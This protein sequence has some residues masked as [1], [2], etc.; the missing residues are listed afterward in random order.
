M[1]FVDEQPDVLF[2][3]SGG[4]EEAAAHVLEED[5][6]YTLIS[7]MEGN[8]NAAAT[9]VK[10]YYN[11]KGAR[12]ILLDYDDRGTP[13]FLKDLYEAL[14]GIKNLQG[15]TLGLLGE[16]SSWLI[17]SAIQP[18]LLKTKLGIELKRIAWDSLPNYKEQIVAEDLVQ[19][20]NSEIPLKDAGKVYTLLQ[21]W[22]E[23][24]KLD[25]ITVECFSL[26]T[27]NAVTA[28]LPLAKLNADG[29]PAGCEGDL[30]SIT[31]M[32]LAK[33]VTGIVP[34]IA[35]TVKVSPDAA[36]FAH[37]TA[38][39]TLLTEHTVTTH[40]ETGKGT[41]I[42]GRWATDNITIFRLNNTLNNAFIAPGKVLQRPRH[43]EA[44]RTQIEVK[45]PES[46]VYSL[47]ENPLGNHHLILPHDYTAT[48][49]LAC[50]VLGI[51]L[52]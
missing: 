27:E 3:L 47:R 22:I 33:E 7:F 49:S 5:K 26:I 30:V 32:M 35:N 15:Q 4:S 14:K 16:V 44:C 51:E 52:Q 41:A 45:L 21:H 31:G 48:L 50:H 8:S 12:S 19:T 6:F 43:A 46:A 40:F 29:F 17:A 36:L 23:R 34:W 13:Y 38:A 2:F 10:A 18:A 42:Q 24:E 1:E 25:A 20:F 11:Q 39:P 37:C 28:C 9:E